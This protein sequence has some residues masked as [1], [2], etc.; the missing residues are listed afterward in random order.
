[1]QFNRQRTNLIDCDEHGTGT[2]LFVVEGLSASNS[3]ARVRDARFQ[4]VLPMQGKPMNAAKASRQSVRRNEWFV[5]LVDA[6]GCG[7]EPT[8]N[9]SMRFDRVLLLFDPDADGIHCGLL[10]LLFFER[11][12]RPILESNRLSVVKAPMFEIRATG[13]GDRLHAY[14]ED[15][16]RRLR[17]AL[18]ERKIDHRSQRYRGLASLS[19]GALHETCIDPESRTAHLLEATDAA[20]ARRVLGPKKKAML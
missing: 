12:L 10:V 1:M 13:Y 20:E 14:S 7:W 2:E 18:D 8:S 16:L 3:V 5:A 9:A 17:E 15:H 4:A 19:A 11:Y 6:L